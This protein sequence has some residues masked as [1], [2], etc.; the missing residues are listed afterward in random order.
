MS[1]QHKLLI[2]VP[3]TAQGDLIAF[4]MMEETKKLETYYTA[5]YAAV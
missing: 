3:T 4:Y 1:I 5:G 2:S